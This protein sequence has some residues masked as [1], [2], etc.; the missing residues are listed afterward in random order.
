[1]THTCHWPGCPVEVPPAMWGC[2]PHW[3]AL[4]YGL[5]SK[6][7]RAYRPGQ[8]ITKTPSVEYITV[9]REVQAWI[10]NAAPKPGSAAAEHR[11][12]RY[13]RHPRG[14]QSLFGD[15]T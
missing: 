11:P 7:W 10:A 1:M 13:K 4:P 3:Y 8:E 6:V 5:R 15:P 2:R 12:P 14:Q 9:A